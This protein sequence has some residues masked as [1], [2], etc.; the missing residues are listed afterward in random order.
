MMEEARS[1]RPSSLPPFQHVKAGNA[2]FFRR[3]PISNKGDKEEILGNAQI[4]TADLVM[5]AIKSC[6]NSKAFSL[7]KL[8]I[9]HLKYIGPRAIE[10]IIALSNLSVTFRLYGSLH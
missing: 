8:S 9:C 4:F 6:L 2:H 3:D 7:D 10:Y 5:R 1:Y